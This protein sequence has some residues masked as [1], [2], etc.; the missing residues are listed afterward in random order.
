MLRSKPNSLATAG[1]TE[2]E[3]KW[4]CHPEQGGLCPPHGLAPRTSQPAR[5]KAQRE[6]FPRHAAANM[7]SKHPFTNSSYVRKHKPK[8]VFAQSLSPHLS[9]GQDIESWL[10]A[11]PFRSK[12]Y[13][14]LLW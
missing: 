14:E 7:G 13:R 6:S 10:Q 1:G 9:S 11:H 4:L 8:Q 2:Q 5:I 12:S 3:E